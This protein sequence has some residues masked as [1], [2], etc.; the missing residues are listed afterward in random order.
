MAYN[1]LRAAC[2]LSIA[3]VLVSQL[4]FPV[5]AEIYSFTDTPTMDVTYSPPIPNGTNTNFTHYSS[6][7]R[8]RYT[9]HSFNVDMTGAYTITATTSPVLN[10]MYVLDGIFIPSDTFPPS[11]PISQFIASNFNGTN[12]SELSNVPLT[13][14]QTYS[15]LVAYDYDFDE[16]NYSVLL[17]FNGQGCVNVQYNVCLSASPIV[18]D[19]QMTEEFKLQAAQQGLMLSDMQSG[20][21][22]GQLRQRMQVGGIERMPAG[23]LVHAYASEGRNDAPSVFDLIMIGDDTSSRWTAWEDTG[24]EGLR[25]NW[26]PE[27]R[28]YQASQ[29]FGLDYRFANGWVGGASV[30]ASIFGNDFDNGGELS[31]NAY[32]ISPYLGMQFD[33][34]MITLQVAYT[35]VDYDGF[36]SGTGISGSTHGQRFSGSF[37]VAR[38]FDLGSA[39]YVIPEVTLSAGGERIS[40]VSVLAD[41]N[42][43]DPRFFS[44]KIGGELGYNLSNESRVYALALGEYAITNADSSASYLSTGYQSQEWSATLGGGFD[45]KLAD[46]TGITLEGRLRGIGSNTLIY[47]GNARLNVQF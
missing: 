26:S 3:G 42:V 13:Q 28:G 19:A 47:S 24:A 33:D 36:N 9:L 14:G 35:Y 31:G 11:T 12:T 1:V 2:R 21:V 29:Q 6:G 22:V 16:T 20:A 40:D 30:G 41:G 23:S 7:N 32:W 17:T 37:S 25:G 38:R 10:T 18:T 46:R 4:H 44:T 5:K 15:V 27:V 43:D 34:W 45:L 39:F 8:W